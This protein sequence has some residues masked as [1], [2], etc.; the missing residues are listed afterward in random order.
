MGNPAD[1]QWQNIAMR[2]IE[3]GWEQ[4]PLKVRARYESDG[5]PAPTKYLIGETMKFDGKYAP[6]LFS[7]QVY[8]KN[9]I[10]EIIWIWIMRTNKIS[11]LRKRG[12]KIWDNWV[13]EDGKYKDTIGPAY[14]F[15]LGKNCR[16]YPVS[17]IDFD[18]LTKGYQLEMDLESG[19]EFIMLDQVDY[20][21]QE[22]INNPTSRRLITNI[23]D[24]DSLDDMYLEPCVYG[25]E[26]FVDEDN[27]L[28]LICHARSQDFCVGTPF[29][30]FQYYVLQCVIAKVTGKTV[31][32]MT[33]H[34]GNVHIYSRHIDNATRMIRYNTLG[35]RATVEIDDSVK[36]LVDFDVD[37]YIVK[38]YKDQHMGPLK[39]EIAE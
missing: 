25:T 5:A 24:V 26:W 7:K 39:F 21:I 1:V 34:M 18:A 8:Q 2:I 37:K 6:I 31:G 3:E 14:G 4:N 33:Y 19:E 15:I 9:A 36:N 17:K 10:H 22:L 13:F 35:L 29:N 30:L 38:G 28:H 16:R 23:W 27:A 20:L 32:S 12:V 11:E